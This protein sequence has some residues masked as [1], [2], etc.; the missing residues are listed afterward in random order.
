CEYSVDEY[1]D[2][3]EDVNVD[4]AMRKDDHVETAK[5][6]HSHHTDMTRL[7]QFIKDKV[8]ISTD[9]PPHL[10]MKIDH[11]LITVTN[12]LI[13]E[14]AQTMTGKLTLYLMWRDDRLRW[15]P[16]EFGN[17]KHLTISRREIW[18]PFFDAMNSINPFSDTDYM[19]KYRNAYLWSDANGTTGL[20]WLC[21]IQ[22]VTVDCEV[23]VIS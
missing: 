2:D 19:G 17:A 21:P 18:T 3:Y 7:H 1:D 20:T 23:T 6:V 14:H 5:V 10:P 22:Q 13:D 9:R 8:N 4:Q 11:G 16:S 12:I 15:K